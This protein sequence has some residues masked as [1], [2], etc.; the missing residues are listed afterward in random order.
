MKPL[1]NC[2]APLFNRRGYARSPSPS[3]QLIIIEGFEHDGIKD[4]FSLNW[5][6]C[7]AP[8]FTRWSHLPRDGSSAMLLYDATLWQPQVWFELMFSWCKQ[9]RQLVNHFIVR[10]SF[11]QRKFGALVVNEQNQS[12]RFEQRHPQ[13]PKPLLQPTSQLRRWFASWSFH[14]THCDVLD[15]A[16]WKRIAFPDLALLWHLQCHK[17]SLSHHFHNTHRWRSQAF[18]LRLQTPL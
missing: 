12:P 10:T 17:S 13:T 16:Q 14:P 15:L 7:F 9:L 1:T 6:T 4:W 2:K 3:P 18:G 11:E 8:D 5:E